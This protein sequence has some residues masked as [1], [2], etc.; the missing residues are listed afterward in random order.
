MMGPWRFTLLGDQMGFGHP[1][2]LLVALFFLLLIPVGVI[3]GLRRRRR[4]AAVLGDRLGPQLSPGVSVARPVWRAT[5]QCLGLALL[6]IALSQP[7]CGGTT[8]PVI[9]KGLD[10]VVALD[11]SKSM[12]AR[13]VEPDRISRARLEL[14]TLLDSLK[15]DRVGIVAFAGEAHVQCPMTSDYAAAKLFLRAVNPDDMPQGGTNVGDALRLSKRML[16]ETGSGT[17]DRVVVL[18]S[19]GEDLEGGASE[20]AQ[21][22][23]SAGIRVF[24]VGIGSEDGEPVPRLDRKGRFL[25][26]QKDSD[27]QTV[28]SRL[29][30]QGLRAL[31][32]VTEGAYFHAPR[33]VAIE[34][35]VSL[36]D[37]MKKAEYES[38]VTYRYN[39][40]FQVF[41]AAGLF[42]WALGLLL[43]ASS[44]RREE[45]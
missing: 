10:V 45:A 1:W 22:L 43:S 23:A 14:T 19:D 5:L 33:G 4:V 32:D 21:E 15:G 16:E 41:G 29:D 40:Q 37:R 34:Q 7:Q 20:A 2:A 28:V 12:L 36:L 44:R 8:E 38:R 6:G 18:L 31:A 25:D 42:L 39:E 35:V 30:A 13:D 11:A 24:V 9:R 3:S 17:Q 26:F 27:G